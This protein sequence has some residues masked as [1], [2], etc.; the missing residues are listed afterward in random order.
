MKAIKRGLGPGCHQRPRSLVGLKKEVACCEGSC[1]RELWAASRGWGPQSPNFKELNSA[2]N[3]ASLKENP[4]HRVRP[5]PQ[6]TPGLQPGETVTQRIN[7]SH[8]WTP[9]RGNN[10]IT[11]TCC[12]S[13]LRFGWSLHSKLENCYSLS[14]Q[15]FST[16]HIWFKHERQPQYL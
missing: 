7:R 10:G 5:Q 15:Y 1:G 8:A 2:N 3:K 13:P 14:L 9:D 16:I 11:N 6:P 4:E 12:F